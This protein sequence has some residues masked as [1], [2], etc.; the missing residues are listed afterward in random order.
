MAKRR[1]RLW[2][3]R[4]LRGG[5]RFVRRLKALMGSFVIDLCAMTFGMPRALFPV[6]SLTVFHAGAG[7][8]QECFSEL[9]R[10]GSSARVERVDIDTTRQAPSELRLLEMRDPTFRGASR[11]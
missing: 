5:L 2:C 4:R 3:R 6:L 11:R 1:T 9:D 10:H 8:A 7:S